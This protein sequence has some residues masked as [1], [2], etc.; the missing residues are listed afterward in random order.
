MLEYSDPNSH[1]MQ[2]RTIKIYVILVTLVIILI[3]CL[4]T[5]SSTDTDDIYIKDL[6]L[7]TRS[8]YLQ[9]Q[10]VYIYHDLQNGDKT[11]PIGLYV[12]RTN[13]N[14]TEIYGRKATFTHPNNWVASYDL[15]E[16]F[17]MPTKT[18]TVASESQLTNCSFADYQGHSG[19]LNP[20][21]ICVLEKS[22]II[23]F[24]NLP[25]ISPTSNLLPN[26]TK[27]VILPYQDIQPVKISKFNKI[28]RLSMR[29]IA[30]EQLQNYVD[31]FT[32]MAPDYQM[33]L[34]WETEKENVIVS[35]KFEIEYDNLLDEFKLV[36][37][38]P[39]S[40]GQ[41]PSSPVNPKNSQTPSIDTTTTIIP[42]VR[43]TLRKKRSNLTNDSELPVSDLATPEILKQRQSHIFTQNLM[44][45]C[46]R[47]IQQPDITTYYKT[48]F[49]TFTV[50]LNTHTST[51][52]DLKQQS[53][54]HTTQEINYLQ[55]FEKLNIYTHNLLVF[56]NKRNEYVHNGKYRFML[57]VKTSYIPQ[58]VKKANFIEKMFINWMNLD[59]DAI[60]DRQEFK[61][62][63]EKISK[64]ETFTAKSKYFY[65]KLTFERNARW[66]NQQLHLFCNPNSSFYYKKLLTYQ[67]QPIKIYCT[68]DYKDN[69]IQSWYLAGWSK[70]YQGLCDNLS[71]KVNKFYYWAGGLASSLLF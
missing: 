19:N 52:N 65:A 44:P 60:L 32:T 39:K 10:Q 70:Y 6:E 11:S 33:M 23:S 62:L 25:T 31:L 30:L 35:D 69:Y 38:F 20:S 42:E 59:I 29:Q 36:H 3:S 21:N 17:Y 63:Q 2:E 26:Q 55:D 12:D 46:L 67:K 7:Y 66:R 49:V 71:L 8:Q 54:Y 50:D 43:S 40:P 41:A 18:V 51:L 9:C 1:I 16:Y 5:F 68:S 57:P 48:C 61:K 37:A 15:Y 53:N 14:D 24:K 64:L 28:H 58:P 27:T 56:K 13:T 22:K 4:I 47:S 34:P 45:I